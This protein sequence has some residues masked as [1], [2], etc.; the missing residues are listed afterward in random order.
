MAKP[1]IVSQEKWDGLKDFVTNNLQNYINKDYGFDVFENDSEE[2]FTDE[3]QN[4]S[5]RY[6]LLLE[7]GLLS[8]GDRSSAPHNAIAILVTAFADDMWLLYTKRN[9]DSYKVQPIGFG[10]FPDR[11]TTNKAAD[12]VKK[13]FG[14]VLETT[15]ALDSQGNEYNRAFFNNGGG[16]TRAYRIP[17][18]TASP[19]RG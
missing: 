3:M 16:V 17:V 13:Y 10:W 1:L 8:I 2:R 9:S 18:L 19:L 14:A 15:I 5:Y 7:D 11:K 6:G 4:T 12:E